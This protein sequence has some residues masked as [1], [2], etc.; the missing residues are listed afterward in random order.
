M[1]FER[2]SSRGHIPHNSKMCSESHVL[3]HIFKGSIVIS[4][5]TDGRHSKHSLE[6]QQ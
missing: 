1:D 5:Q 2:M 3:E 6:C 4:N